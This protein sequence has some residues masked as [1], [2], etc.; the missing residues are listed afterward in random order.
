MR[1]KNMNKKFPEPELCDKSISIKISCLM[2]QW[3]LQ[4]IQSTV[5]FEFLLYII[6][7]AKHFRKC[8]GV[9]C[10]F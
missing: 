9:P 6:Y 10:K 8:I 2:L 1:I 3:Q 5:C 7:C 4:N